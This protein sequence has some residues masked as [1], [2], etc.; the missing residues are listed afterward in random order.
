MEEGESWPQGNI[1]NTSSKEEIAMYRSG[2]VPESRGT[3]E[4]RS[5]PSVVQQISSSLVAE[6][7]SGTIEMWYP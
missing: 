7:D 6:D 3:Y 2:I 4:C 1:L 5:R